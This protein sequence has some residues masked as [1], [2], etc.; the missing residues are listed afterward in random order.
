[1]DRKFEAVNML[2]NF[3]AVLR[4]L[5]KNV[6]R[7]KPGYFRLHSNFKLKVKHNG[8]WYEEDGSTLHEVVTFKQLGDVPK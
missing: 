3:G 1:V 8:T 6:L 2:D 7:I 4:F 5:A